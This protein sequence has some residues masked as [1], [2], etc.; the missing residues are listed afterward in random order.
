MLHQNRTLCST[1]YIPSTY[2]LAFLQLYPFNIKK[3][4]SFMIQL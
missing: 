2:D 3:K 4:M 1:L